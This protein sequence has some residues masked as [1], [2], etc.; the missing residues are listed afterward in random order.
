MSCILIRSRYC[1]VLVLFCGIQKSMVCGSGV[2]G[3]WLWCPG[4]VALVSRVCCSGVQV[5]LLWYSRIR[6]SGVHDT[7][8]CGLGCVVPWS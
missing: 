1:M 5:M 4:Y 7:L 2:Q 6:C 8:F 3:M